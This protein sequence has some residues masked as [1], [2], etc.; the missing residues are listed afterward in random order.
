MNSIKLLGVMTAPKCSKTVVMCD[1]ACHR[2]CYKSS[3]NV[4]IHFLS[5]FYSLEIKIFEWNGDTE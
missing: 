5:Y 2:T 4:Y 1:T 3:C